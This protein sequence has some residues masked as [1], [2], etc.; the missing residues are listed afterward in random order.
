MNHLDRILEL[1]NDLSALQKRC[2]DNYYTITD[3]EN[4][5]LSKLDIAVKALKFYSDENNYNHFPATSAENCIKFVG[6]IEENEPGNLARQ[7]LKE[8]KE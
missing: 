7:A 8:I 6:F 1:E 4:K 2:E 5:L 3:I